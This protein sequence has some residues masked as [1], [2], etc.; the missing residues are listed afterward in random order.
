MKQLTLLVLTALLL[1]SCAT[2]RIKSI[3]EVKSSATVEVS[4]KTVTEGKVVDKGTTETVRTVETVEEKP[5]VVKSVDV[6]LKNG[7]T[8]NKDSLGNVIKVTLDSLKQALTIDVDFAG[9]WVKTVTNE[10]VNEVRDYTSNTEVRSEKDSLDKRSEVN[11]EVHTDRKS[12]PSIKFWIV[13]ALIVG[14]AWW[15]IKKIA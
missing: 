1:T 13:F 5:R 7:V 14:A 4:S 10:R 3:D 2:R 12:T 6:P 9:G 8:V 11:R 15:F